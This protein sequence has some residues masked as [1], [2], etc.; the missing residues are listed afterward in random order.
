M[1]G[2]RK[3]TPYACNVWNTPKS[4]I[5]LDLSRG[6]WRKTKKTKPIQSNPKNSI[7]TQRL[8]KKIKRERECIKKKG[9]NKKRTF[10]FD[11]PPFWCAN[12]QMGLLLDSS[13]SSS[14]SLPFSQNWKKKKRVNNA[15]VDY[16]KQQYFNKSIV[17]FN[18]F[19]NL[20]YNLVLVKYY[21][22]RN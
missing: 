4:L 19:I 17:L 5:R 3:H 16:F 7:K 20:K 21:F 6:I 2:I 11:S 18:K 10:E 13:S 9:R 1:V 12:T 22:K 15:R 8:K 14:S